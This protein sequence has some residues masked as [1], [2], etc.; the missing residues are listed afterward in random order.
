MNNQSYFTFKVERLQRLNGSAGLSWRLI[1]ESKN[2]TK[3]SGRIQFEDG[4]IQQIITVPLD[5]SKHDKPTRL[6]LF[7]TTNMY[8]LGRWKMAKI[9]FVC[10]F[11]SC[12]NLCRLCYRIHILS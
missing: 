9:S 12:I 6:E 4:Q 5:K 2:L 10:K 8:N 1:Y 7:N 11:Y 3:T